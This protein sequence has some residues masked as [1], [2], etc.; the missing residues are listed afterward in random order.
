MTDDEVD[1]IAEKVVA[2]IKRQEIAATVLAHHKK[3]AL[4][5]EQAS[6]KFCFAVWIAQ[7]ADLTVT[8]E[9]NSHGKG[10]LTRPVS[11]TVLTPDGCDISQNTLRPTGHTWYT[12]SDDFNSSSTSPTPPAE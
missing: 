5:V 2:T 8:L 10:L 9:L 7:Q 1:A 6:V 12:P 4:E 3:L 11:V